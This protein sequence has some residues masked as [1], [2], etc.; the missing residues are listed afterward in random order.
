MPHRKITV[1]ALL[2]LWVVTRLGLPATFATP[3][4]LPLDGGVVDP[5]FVSA[6][7]D[8]PSVVAVQADGKILVATAAAS[9]TSARLVRLNADGSLDASYHIDSTALGAWVAS[10]SPQ[11]DG[12]ALVATAAHSYSPTHLVHL[13]A[14]GSTDDTYVQPPAGVRLATGD[15]LQFSVPSPYTAV[16]V[17]RVHADGVVA[18]SFY[19][20]IELP[21]P[22]TPSNANFAD[23]R[24]LTAFDSQGRLVVAVS[25]SQQ[26]G[27]MI[28]GTNLTRF[29]RLLGDGSF[30]SSFVSAFLGEAIFKLL[31][32]PGS[33]KL[34][35][36]AT[37]HSGSLGAVINTKFGRLNADASVD[38]SY[39][40]ITDSGNG[41]Y[42]GISSFGADPSGGFL[43]LS[44]DHHSVVRYT[45]DGEADA[46]FALDLAPVTSLINAS[47]TGLTPLVDGRLLV[48][49]N[50]TQR[51]YLTRFYPATHDATT[52][53]VNLSVRSAAGTGSATVIV[54]F[55]VTGQGSKSVLVRT[56]GPGLGDLIVPDHLLD[57]RLTLFH[58]SDTLLTNDDWGSAADP[59]ALISTGARL[60]AFPLISGSKDAAAVTALAAGAY[61][62]HLSAADTVSHVGLAEVY[63]ADGVPSDFD[64]P[65]LVNI[66]TRAAAGTGSET[67]IA[68]FVISG[69]SAKRVLV[70]A[71]GPGL[72]GQ[73]VS[74]P[75]ADPQLY[76]YAGST[77]IGF[78]GDWGND[79]KIQGAAAN[80]GAF[81]LSAGSKD[82]ALLLTLPPGVYSAQASAAD[83]AKGIVLLEIYEV[84]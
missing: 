64:A 19:V 30:D 39:A 59:Q 23:S 1:P 13:K 27:S 41:S 57:P 45:A 50:G 40:P 9:P 54:G 67:L 26:V 76:L 35:Y 60:G 62:M 48:T 84:P 32:A 79:A 78:N 77:Q 14:D 74:N 49:G 37:W 10:V 72:A 80:V 73:G 22:A 5:T 31:C 56:V 82:A 70:R 16:L 63:D 53:L 3:T 55:V 65:R 44:S 7:T 68:G 11:P 15:Y 29:F 38:T 75:I 47:I 8:E 43:V 20:T 25:T 17:T 66:S 12:S 34:Y 81:S 2:L 21:S 36:Y 18:D 71:V 4:F 33:D 61:S 83:G 28:L 52:R 51:A 58:G 42:T 6:L 24:F 69:P 46:N